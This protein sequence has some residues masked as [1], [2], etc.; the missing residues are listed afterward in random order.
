MKKVARNILLA[1]GLWLRLDAAAESL[2]QSRQEFARA[3]LD[4]AATRQEGK[5]ARKEGKA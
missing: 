1:P 5:L 4:A 2:G 3:A